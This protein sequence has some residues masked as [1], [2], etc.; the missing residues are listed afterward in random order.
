MRLALMTTECAQVGAAM[1]E[2]ITEHR[3]DLKLVVTSNVERPQRGGAVSQTLEN[4]RRSG[5]AFVAYLAFSFPLYDLWLVLDRARS[6]VGL[7]RRRRSVAELCAEY[8][9]RH[10][11]VDDVNAPEVLDALRAEEVELLTI[12][13]FD[14]ILRQATID[15][16][17]RG[18]VNFHAARLPEC[19]GLFPV[20]F[21]AI[22]NGARFGMTAHEIV[23][24]TI[25]T[26]PILGQIE[27]VARA[28]T[29]LEQDDLVNRAGVGFYTE[30]L[31]HLEVRRAGATLQSGGS[32]F[33]FPTREQVKACRD[34]GFGLVSAGAFLRVVG[35]AAGGTRRP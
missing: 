31:D 1:E 27:V 17:P 9:I 24:E 12:Y 18:V 11:K 7:A 19:R 29:V 3:D 6:R 26:G 4:L 22:E 8:D 16:L 33:S 21:S 2:L 15:A 13:W 14:Q 34:A 10:I 32:Y 20:L 30:V 28:G 35:R 25:D 5:P 23:D